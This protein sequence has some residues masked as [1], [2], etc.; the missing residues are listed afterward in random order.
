MATPTTR[1]APTPAPATQHVANVTWVDQLCQGP[2]AD[3]FASQPALQRWKTTIFMY[4]ILTAVVVLVL[5]YQYITRRLATGPVAPEAPRRLPTRERAVSPKK[6]VVVAAPKSPSR[7][8]A[9]K[10]VAPVAEESAPAPVASPKARK[11]R[12]SAAP[13]VESAPVEAEP[14]VAPYVP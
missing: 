4:F 2:C 7:S 6:E 10:K 1:P 14:V 8:R 13:V 3:F 5:L 11:P 9:P 12:K